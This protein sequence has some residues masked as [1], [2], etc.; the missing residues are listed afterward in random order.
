MYKKLKDL[1]KYY[2]QNIYELDEC[3]IPIEK[4]AEKSNEIN[5]TSHKLILARIQNMLFDQL[6][7]NLCKL[8]DSPSDKYPTVSIPSILRYLNDN[9]GDLTK[10]DLKE[11]SE[12]FFQDKGSLTILEDSIMKSICSRY[13]QEIDDKEGILKRFKD[14][15]DKNIAHNEAVELDKLG[16][17]S[18]KDAMEL[19]S[20]AEEFRDCVNYCFFDKGGSGYISDLGSVKESMN[21]LIQAIL[22]K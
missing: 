2:K 14:I 13:K 22:Y 15:R 3:I 7:L 9:E 1:L 10:P 11:R 16:E 21:T 5:V 6:I 17:I 4:I 18:W 12:V 8:F 19:K 20:L